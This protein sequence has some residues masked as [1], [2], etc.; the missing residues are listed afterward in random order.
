MS[1]PFNAERPR[2]YLPRLFLALSLALI[3]VAQ[4]LTAA[5]SSV[6]LASVP[7][8]ATLGAVVTLNAIVTPGAATGKITFYDGTTVLGTSTLAN[9]AASLATIQ[10]PQGFRF[11]RARYSGDANFSPSISQP[12]PQTVSAVAAGPFPAAVPYAAGTD[13]VSLAAG[14]FNGDGKEDIVSAATGGGVNV[15]LGNGDGTFRAAVNYDAGIVPYSVTTGDFNGDGKTDLAVGDLAGIVSILLG[16][17]NGTF[18]V[19]TNYTPDGSPLSV[20]VGDFNGDGKPD[21]AIANNGPDTVGILLGNGD[22]TFTA[23]GSYPAGSN[24]WSVAV[25]DFNGDGIADIVAISNSAGTNVKVLLGN[26][27]G[28]FTAGA[29]YSAGANLLSVALEDYDA[30]GNLDIAVASFNNSVN[31]LLGTGFGTFQTAVSYPVDIAVR[32]I[33]TGDFNGDGIVDLAGAGASPNGGFAVVLQ[34]LGDGSFATPVDFA[35]GHHP[36]AITTADFSSDGRADLAVAETGGQGVFILLGAPAQP[37]LTVAS[38]HTGNFTL[39]QTDA[40]YTITV[41]NAGQAPTTAAVTVNDTL[42]ASLVPTSIGGSGWSCTLSPLRCT[43]A[44]TGNDAAPAQTPFSAITL[45]VNVAANAPASVTNNVTVSGG[46]ETNTSND[47]GTD[48]TLVQPP[49]LVISADTLPYAIIGAPYSFT[50]SASGGV[51]GYGNWRVASGS[52]PPGLRLE[53]GPGTIDG[54]PTSSAN[55]P[56]NFTVTVQDS[57]GNTSQ[58]Q[59]FTIT[60]APPLSVTAA[61]LPG[62]EVA[63]AYTAQLAASGGAPPYGNWTV[64]AGSLGPNLSLDPDT[65]IIS[66]TPTNTAGSPFTF[67]VT[68]QDNFATISAPRSFSVSVAPQ[69]V[70]TAAALPGGEVNAF[71]SVAL[72]ASGGV[73]PYG[74]WTVSVGTLP[75]GLTLNAS[76]GLISG[77]PTNATGSPFNFSVTLRDALGA[78]AAAQT[79]SI[80]IAPAVAVSATSLT[81]GVVGAAY[82]ATLV[83]TGGISPYSNWTVSAGSLPAGLSLNSATGAISGTPTSAA[84]SPFSFSVTVK[85]S[86]GNASAG[87]AF[88]LVISPAV[89]ITPATLPTGEVSASYSTSLAA[90]G[91]VPPYGTWTVS[92]GSLPPGLTLNAGTGVISGTPTNAAGS[93][94]AFSVT[95]KDN[96]GHTSAA[97]VFSVTV[98]AGPS[99]TAAALPNGAVGVAYST[100]LAAASGSAPY[101]NWAVSAGTLPPG[102][103]LNAN[104]GAISGTPNSASGSPFGFSVTVRDNAGG[105]SAA[106]AFSITIAAAVTVTPSN[107]GNGEVSFPYSVTLAATGGSAPY[108]NWTVSAGAL[109][110]G[111]TLNPGVGLISGTP[112]NAAGSP[113][114]FSVTVKDSAAATSAPQA[115]SITI[116]PQ[117]AVATLTMAGGEV[118]AAY[119]VTL[120]ATGG[121][122]PYSNWTVS[123]GALPAG[124][125]LN[126]A[127]GVISGTPTNAAGSPFNFSVTVKDAFGAT[128]VSQ[129]L[130]IAVL[131]QVSV[132]TAAVPGGQVGAAYS[133]T[134]GAGGGTAPYSN[135]TVSAG[136]LPPGL[137]LNAATGVI[138]GTPTSAAGSPFGFS[139]TVRDAVGVTSAAQVL[140]IAILPQLVVTASS[141]ATGEVGVVY[142]AGLAASGGSLPYSNWTVNGGAL[143]PGLSLNAATGVIGG[144]PTTT[145]GS[146]FSFSVTVTD[147][148]GH[149]S[150]G[151]AFQIAIAPAVVV[152]AAALPAGAVNASYSATLAATGGVTPYSNWT[153]S[154]GSLPTGVTLNAASGTIGGTPT[155]TA[156]SPFAFSVTTQDSAGKVSAAQA[157]SITV[158]SA[159][160]VTPAALGSGVVGAVYSATLAASGGS[161]PYSNW[162]VSAG[163]LPSGLTLNSATGAISGTPNSAA[164]SPFNF[165]VTARDNAGS[166]SAAQAFS[167]AIAPPVSITATSLPVGEVSAA[168]S[169][170][171]S[172]TGG[173]PPYNNWTI[174]AGSLPP[175][176]SLNAGT[177][178]I[179]GTPTS[180]AGSPFGFSVTA[181]DSAGNSSAAQAFSMAISTV[182]TVTTTSAP[183]GAVGS[184]YSTTLAASGGTPPYGTWTVS[185]GALPPGL[186]LN[187]GTGAI[188]GIPTTAAGSPF[189]F[190][191]TV[192][193]GSNAT[194][195][196][197]ALQI[198]IAP[199]VTVATGALGGGE[200]GAIYSTTL[201]A[202]NGIAPYSAWTVSAGSLPPGL[203]LNAASGS[204]SGTPT[205][206]AGSP[207][208]FSVTV[209]DSGGAISVPQALSIAIASQV[210]VT[211]TT[212]PAGEVGVGYSATLAAS[213]GT[214]PYNTWTV[215][216]GS[217]PPGLNLNAG[218]G[219]IS[220]T[221]TTAAGSPYSFT[222]TAKDGF[223]NTSAGQSFSIVIATAVVVTANA[224]PA[225]EVGVSYLATLGATGGVQPFSNW[226]V[227]A[228]ALPAGLTLNAATGAISGTPAN[229]AGSPF[230][231]SVT[232][233]DGAGNTS[234]SQAFSIAV[235]GAVTVTAAALPGGAVGAL[236]SA[237]LAASGGFA[238]YSNWTVSAGSLPPGLALN[239]GNGAI[240]GT[241]NNA[242]GSP[243]AFSVT[244][245]DNAGNTSAAQAFSISIAATVTVSTTSPGAG[246]IA[247]AYQSTLAAAGGTPP[248][249][250][251]TVSAGSLPP[252]LSLNAASGVISGTPTS[253]AGSPFAFSVTVRDANNVTSAAQALSIAVLPTVVISSASVPGGEVGVIYSTG[254]TAAGGAPP[255]SNWTVSA[256][257]LPPGLLLNA[258]SGAIGGTPTSA[259]GSP[260]GFSVTVKDAAGVTSAAQAF[261]L[262]VLSQLTITT[263]AVPV[264]E[265]GTAYSTTLAVSGGSAP[266]SN[267]TVSAGS[268]PPGLQLNAANGVI[269]G[270]PT[271][272]A[273]SPFGFSV[274]VTDRAGV[275]SS[276]QALSIAIAPSV[277]VQAASLPSGV[278][279]TAYSATL[280][281]NNGVAPYSTWAVSAG[282]LPPGLSLNAGTGAMSGTPTT[283]AG[284]PFSFI[285]TVKDAAGATS[286]GQAFSIVIAP[287]V[288]VTAATLPTGEV[289]A[290][291]AASL[292]ATGGVAPYGNWTVS[293]GS[294][295][296]GLTLDVNS[297]V[298]SGTPTNALG[299]PF[300]FSVTAKDSSGNASAAQ[301][302]SITVNSAVM[303]TPT[304]PG[305]GVVGFA[306]SATLTASGGSAP[307]SNWTVTGGILPPGLSINAGTGTISG[308]PTTLTGS[309]FGFGVS[310]KDGAGNTSATQ[311]FSITIAG[312]VTVTTTTVPAGNV[313][314]PYSSTL[315]A[316]GGLPPYGN[317]AV[318]AGSLPPGLQLNAATGVISGTPTGA[319]GSPFGFSVTAQ[320]SAGHPSA[321]QALSI[322]VAQQVIINF[323]P[324]P[325]SAV[326]I[327]YSTTLTASGG[328]VP[329]RNWVVV[330]GAL[331]PGLVLDASTGTISGAP[332]SAVGSPFVF[333]VTVSDSSGNPSVA[334]PFQI[335]VAPPLSVSTTTLPD[336][337]AGMTYSAQL[338]AVGGALPY[339]KWT[340]VGALPAGVTLNTATGV[341]SGAPSTTAGSPFIFAISVTDAAGTVSDIRVLTI[342][343][344][345]AV[346]ITA[347]NLPNGLVGA[348]YTATL[349]ATGGTPPYGQW[350][351]ITGK[352]PPGLNLDTAAGTI[353][354]LPVTANGSPFRFEVSMKDKHGFA[355]PAQVFTIVVAGNAAAPVIT[356][357]GIGPVYSSSTTIEAGSWISIY[358]TNLASTTATW[359]GDFPT[360]LGGVSVT[361][362]GKPAYLWY[363]S[364]TQINLQAPDDTQTGPV[365]V[366]LTNANGSVASTVTLAATG[367]SLSLLGDGKHVA[368]VIITPNGSGAYGGGGYDL[369]GPRSA[370]AFNTRPV[371]QG[372]VLVLFGVGFGATNPAVPAGQLF[373]GAAPTVNPVTFTIGG[374]DAAVSFAGI[375]QAGLYQFNL[376]VPNTGS[377]DKV[378]QASVDGAKTPLGVLVSVQ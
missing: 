68:V 317:W 247:A 91:G 133:T 114:N 231:F 266:Y 92:A 128:S 20:K 291:Y 287:A 245:R 249:S 46:G 363:V 111:L 191:V 145:V 173:I 183:S 9:G 169:A 82:S 264:G 289:N 177:G 322:V 297:G 212:P 331:P 71:Y 131:A 376:T 53:P 315:A 243:F 110:A 239:A 157:F 121:S 364:P 214:P 193:D 345:P 320:D 164:G 47:S 314:L 195:A 51:P 215:T 220:G 248:Y 44:A 367:P 57:G 373:S 7:N 167:I 86:P 176:L 11:L 76:T 170:S 39:G 211:G 269:S 107:P 120:A 117:V 132:T 56:Y 237:A 135:W 14:D 97:Q 242:T 74:N 351:L 159:V 222:V 172:A 341:F 294:L 298:I 360:L 230:G 35:T 340:I 286:A 16:N 43:R 125:S 330:D 160:T 229:A 79:F 362:N 296:P 256:G 15:L 105:T 188:S 216:G 4:P 156:G 343:V 323:S 246:E 5:S 45:L 140:S 178:A 113:F 261:S 369:V 304:A 268:L 241:P 283:A 54:T 202:S 158:N 55:S 356:P 141:L 366:V 146:P 251:W 235:N 155:S 29:S 325:A 273:G 112:T 26:G 27:D 218:S 52:L 142:S 365:A 28:T 224:L 78:A 89:T 337:V 36:F 213:G 300:A 277:T 279:G 136:A 346:T 350:S 66:G 199:R 148:G 253:A 316:S 115:F 93:P 182:L 58:A 208:G 282:S 280:T 104:T 370:F 184:A 103:T 307:Y 129:A 295:P 75:A 106:Q 85:D 210:V 12:L 378:V 37:D 84:G 99:V 88:S 285:V 174:S 352:L 255:Y 122:A 40:V 123:A 324:L 228:G 138:N 13:P 23:G 250:N 302:F 312:P 181:K 154:A 238:P 34:G 284:S 308:T 64:S 252:G 81:A 166:T 339:A 197:Q 38:A 50:L 311:T 299:S 119:S 194:S 185:V 313:G 18:G 137:S 139:V 73:T 161:P 25:G 130:S 83:A 227:S 206:A 207:F 70:I 319:V 348:N 180:A 306:Y 77:T 263:A 198:I 3:A 336:A 108:S 257:S 357:G 375:T 67:S 149:T 271:S 165:S 65:G 101:S 48:P 353:S 6:A 274:M 333:K 102:L 134:L 359:N 288:V 32:S 293:A 186:S 371:K 355:A 147:N 281:A 226:A 168:Y 368:G 62:A 143:P 42:P 95:A 372:E 175:G 31:V 347:A 276:A 80:S 10:L 190:S 162:A 201:A 275:T 318:S 22:G 59:S 262:V 338:T 358:G 223:G 124:L 374:V 30:D 118:G 344:V 265:I 204:I 69:V 258:A 171:L 232:V 1:S 196:A 72:A 240:S 17:G 150:A 49:A 377:G 24:L 329:Y 109:P 335:V 234:A 187:A 33:V 321:A 326:G 278:P 144:T 96:A 100:T 259:A 21:L 327:S 205:T 152:S 192:K 200:V 41:T 272:A 2:G 116:L 301:A 63:S 189:S 203:T 221:P 225:G 309:P 305:G 219:T 126:A 61:T 151:Q 127:T 342:N 60:S 19:P 332:V 354:G 244:T 328:V 87:Q 209:N 94:F 303:V 292:V 254:L 260:F 334:Q 310:V 163:L 349:T 361:I 90:T 236:Y 179:G 267:W 217:L 290:T 233:R 98:N 153:V 270:T 8:P